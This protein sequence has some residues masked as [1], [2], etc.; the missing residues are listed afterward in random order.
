MIYFLGKP[1]NYFGETVPQYIGNP[2][3]LDDT[4][5]ATT[6]IL[7]STEFRFDANLIGFE[8]YAIIAGQLRIHV[9]WHF[10]FYLNK[11]LK[12]LIEW[13]NKNNKS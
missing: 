2:I 3:K 7:S 8:I 12:Y 13:T 6:S 5:R 1:L 9:I 4:G 11:K 10:L